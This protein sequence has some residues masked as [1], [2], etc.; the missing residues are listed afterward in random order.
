MIININNIIWKN[1]VEAHKLKKQR[2]IEKSNTTTEVYKYK[3][4]IIQIIQY[5]K[6]ILC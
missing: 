3:K 1:N 5:L 6:D 2:K 4:P